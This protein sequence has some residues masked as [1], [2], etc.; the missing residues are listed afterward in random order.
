MA[1]AAEEL[2]KFGAKSVYASIT[3]AVFSMNALEVLDKSSFDEVLVT[4]TIDYSGQS[5]KI[6]QISIAPLLSQVIT[7]INNGDSVSKLFS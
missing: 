7:R 6:K 3:H 1:K 2:K 5:T 4:D